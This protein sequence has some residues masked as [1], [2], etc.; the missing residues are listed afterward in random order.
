[1]TL[2]PNIVSQITAALGD[3]FA[4]NQHAEQTVDARL[5]ANRKWGARDRR[6]FAESVYENVRWWRLHWQLAGLPDA[7]CLLPESI[8]NERLVTLWESYWARREAIA[9]GAADA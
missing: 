6:L 1:M 7:E 2:H 5:K 9:A 4:R 3:I 8:T